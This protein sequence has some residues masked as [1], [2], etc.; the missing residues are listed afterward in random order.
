MQADGQPGDVSA[1]APA[2]GDRPALAVAAILVSVLALSLG[3]AVIKRASVDH[4]LWQL[5]TLRSVLIVPV[6]A[7]AIALRRTA[8][9]L[10]P[11]APTWILLRSLMLAL[12]W[13]VYYAALPQIE[14]SVAAA[15]YY[16]SP[17]IIVL[18]TIR[19]SRDRATPALGAAAAIGF[20]GVLVMLRPGAGSVDAWVVLPLL[21][22]VLYASAMLVTR[23]R[24]AAEHALVLALALNLAF[25]AAGGAATLALRALDPD[26]RRA[27]ANRFLFGDWTVLGAGE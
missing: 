17:L 2:V 5:Y 11:L 24:C 8:T 27:S 15:A 1:T 9:S 18:L 14:L 13:I 21:A 26:G 23:A 12:M 6:L 4:P 7:G 19:L 16:T 20:A 10:R 22:A 3:D 25:I